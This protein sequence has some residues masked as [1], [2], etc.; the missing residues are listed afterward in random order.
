[1]NAAVSA[2]WLTVAAVAGDLDV[3]PRTVLR[4][5]DA[6]EFPAMRLPGGRLRIRTSDYAVWQEGRM[7]AAVNA[8]GPAALERPGPGTE[9]VPPCNKEA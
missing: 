3:S 5:I 2:G 1:M 4:W 6:G 9:E 8:S 7:I